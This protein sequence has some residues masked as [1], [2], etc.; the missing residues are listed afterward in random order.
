MTEQTIK[1]DDHRALKRYSRGPLGRLW[2]AIEQ[3][4]LAALRL[5]AE[6]EGVTVATI[7]R[8]AISREL[9]AA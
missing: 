2:L 9:E 7:A 4:K 1:Q 8:R 6:T 3:E 5:K